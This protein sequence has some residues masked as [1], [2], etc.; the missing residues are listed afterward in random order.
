MRDRLEGL[1]LAGV[2]HD[3]GKISVPAEILSKPGKLTPIEYTLVKGHAQAGYDI[4]KDIDFPWPIATIVWQHHERADGSGYPL[5]LKG[6][7]ILLESR[8]MAVADVME[9]MA[10]HRPY[11]PTRGVE[12]ALKEIEG[13]RGTLYD[14][15]VVDACLTLF[16]A[17]GFSLPESAAGLQ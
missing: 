3:L 10:S 14:A 15:A 7:E 6:D 1:H 5:G 8:I 11:R 4:L 13:G 16:R 2:V 9:S 17:R 12:A